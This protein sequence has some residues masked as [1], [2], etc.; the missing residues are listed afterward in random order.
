MATIPEILDLLYIDQLPGPNFSS[1]PEECRFFYSEF[2]NLYD[3][4]LNRNDYTEEQLSEQRD[5]TNDNLFHKLAEGYFHWGATWDASL[6]ALS[7]RLYALW[8]EKTRDWERQHNR[9]IH[10]GTQ[11]HQLGWLNERKD[12]L[13][14][15]YD[16]YFM[17]WVEDVVSGRPYDQGQGFRQLNYYFG[18]PKEKLK[19]IARFI[20]RQTEQSPEILIKKIKQKYVIP[21]KLEIDEFDTAKVKD[22]KVKWEE[23]KEV[24]QTEEENTN[25]Q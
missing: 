12:N 10:K 22:I 3:T 16:Y 21:T 1:I 20:R 9:R 25:A 6:L 19:N 11:L 7:E 14:K 13:D 15:A 4:L 17:G 23:L 5:R 8:Y 24:W 18:I 2:S